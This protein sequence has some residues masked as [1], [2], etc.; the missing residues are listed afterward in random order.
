[1]QIQDLF[2]RRIARSINGV[3]K[4]DQRDDASVWQELDEFVVTREL[5]GHL[6]KFLDAFASTLT[7]APDSDATSK[8]GVW[9]SGFFGSGKSH[10]I[11][12]LSYLLKNDLHS[13]E[14][15]QRRAVEFF[16]SK[17]EDAMIL[18]DIRRVATADTDAILFNIDSKADANHGRDAILRVFLK[19]FNEMQGFCA[20]HPE[21]AFMERHLA[22][23][24]KYQTFVEVFRREYGSE[25]ESERDAKDLLRDHV[26]TA[27]SEALGIS[28]DSAEKFFDSGAEAVS[29]T[30]ENLSKWVKEYL[31]EKGP[32]HRIM[33]LVDEVG[34]FIGSDSHLMLSLQTIT[35]NLGTICNGRAWVVVTS[36]EDID[37]VLGQLKRER[38]QDFSKIQGRFRTRLSLSST[39][40]DEVILKRLLA[41]KESVREELKDIFRAK[42]D[43][44]KHQM[45]F[46]HTGMTF[47]HYKEADDFAAH[48][49]FAPYQF[50]LVQKIFEAIRK[51]GATGAHLS[52]GERSI[53]DA[54]Q[55]A[56]KQVADQ[57]LG[58]LVPLYRFYPS[59]ESFL[60]T[61]VKRTIDQAKDNVALQEFDVLL[62]QVLFLV[63]YVDEMKANV[64]NLASLCAEEIDQDRIPLK[65]KIE[66]SLGRL[67]KETLISRNGDLY[68]FLTNEERDI[69]REIKNVDVIASEEATAFGKLIFEDV[70]KDAK[71]F[72]HQATK[73]PFPFNR[74]CDQHTLGHK[75]EAGLPVLVITPL[76][77][78]YESWNKTRCLTESSSRDGGAVVIRLG[79]PGSK[80]A[81][82]L[83]MMLQV[84]R[85]N[86]QKNDGTLPDGTRKILNDLAEE[87]R[88]RRERLVVEVAKLLGEAEY[89]VAGQPL[90]PTKGSAQDFLFESLG[91]L[92][93]NTFTKM[94]YLHKR[95]EGDTSQL[96]QRE[97]QAVLR[98]ND[99]A[100]ARLDLEDVE[101][102]PRA[103]QELRD[104]LRLASSRSSQIVLHDLVET[105]FVR[106]PYG[107]PEEEILL[108][109]ARLMVLGEIHLVMDGAPIPLDRVFEAI[110]NAQKRRKITLVQRKAVDPKAIQSVRQLGKDVFAQMGPDGEDPIVAFLKGKLE[111]WLEDLKRFHGLC[112]DS[113]YPGKVEVDGL[114]KLVKPLLAEKD[115]AT[116]VEAFNAAK[117]DLLDAADAFH[118]LSNFFGPQRAIWDRMKKAFK[119]F[120]GNRLQIEEDEAGQTALRR[121]EEIL[122]MPHPY[123]CV[124][125]G[126]GLIEKLEGVQNLAVAQ[127]RQQ[128]KARI[129]SLLATLRQDGERLQVSSSTF[130][131]CVASLKALQ[132]RVDRQESIPHL[133]QAIDEADHAYAEALHR[134][135]KAYVPPPPVVTPPGKPTVEPEQPKPVIKKTRLV[136]PADLAPKALL[137]SQEDVEAFLMA[138]RAKLE[139][140]LA[141]H[142]RIQIR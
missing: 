43:I 70:Y 142:E 22:K 53:L 13:F 66:E 104:Y 23:R 126:P 115:S 9:I 42:G 3:V 44:L 34:Q 60:D 29:V 83:R 123:G 58:V 102:N 120:D 38:A 135:E 35:E 82:E 130:E 27:L 47:R 40:V 112:E 86:T 74:E 87:N 32:Q 45:S 1:M 72:T 89:F 140:A 95:G 92:V 69:N 110:T 26:I 6:A 84:E 7:H 114:L 20:D 16:E 125:E 5:N 59:I 111:G 4:A 113:G 14:G 61:A 56:A 134:L 37:A 28:P 98:A 101:S 76:A 36:Q 133:K 24:G 51:H 8:T 122:A 138:L 94:G 106:R 117:N 2:E 119:V 139:A 65:R 90:N 80:L 30:P 96:V 31:D 75:S 57:N 124:Q 132:E 121:L 52:R 127:Q 73:R 12:V 25:W 55:S 81:Q 99:V 67:E 48:Y 93:D 39:N 105:R 63:R 41:K 17:V 33:F 100:K 79:D 10:F 46:H 136:K 68:F 50:Q 11:K 18:G 85:Y 71:K 109:V 129:E 21:I 116:F 108:L 15:Q 107:W 118:T 137:E 62:L 141:N 103:I 88:K 131:G 49:P 64:D 19:V 78:D 97:I 91:Y 77:D 128:T 54:F